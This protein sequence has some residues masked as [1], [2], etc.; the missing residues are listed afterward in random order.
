MA[1]TVA[2]HPLFGG[3]TCGYRGYAI[4]IVGI[5]YAREDLL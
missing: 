3:L 4:G 1:L 2:P 5:S